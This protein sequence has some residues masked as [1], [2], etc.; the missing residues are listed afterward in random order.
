MTAERSGAGG[1]GGPGRRGLGHDRL[2]RPL[3]I[4]DD[5][6]VGT[7][8]DLA[9]VPEGLAGDRVG[10]DRDVAHHRPHVPLAEPLGP[11]VA[12]G[13]AGDLVGA[14]ALLLEKLGETRT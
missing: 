9:V 6:L 14:E 8:G 1:D 3:R 11:L 5:D 12:V 2:A 10:R 4:D 7:I 13:V